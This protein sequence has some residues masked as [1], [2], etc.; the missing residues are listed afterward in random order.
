[1]KMIG[2]TQLI[3]SYDLA[4]SFLGESHKTPPPIGT[5]EKSVSRDQIGSVVAST[6][7][8][9][10]FNGLIPDECVRLWLSVRGE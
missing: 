6:F 5:L 2:F 8:G 9:E 4:R 10:R 7:V 1:M 3:R